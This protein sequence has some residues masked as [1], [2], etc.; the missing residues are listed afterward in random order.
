MPVAADALFAWHARPGALDRLLPPWQAVRIEKRGTIDPGQTV[1]LRVGT[2][3]FAVRIEARHG[4]V[5]PGRSF[6]DEQVSGPFARWRHV[7]R[8]VPRG[9]RESTLEDDIE[10][11]LPL[12]AVAQPLAGGA[13]QAALER[14]FRFRHA[15]TR[16]D[17]ERH[18]SAPRQSLRVAI[19]GASGLVGRNLA[20]FLTTGGHEVLR[21]SRDRSSAPDTI[22]W[23][24]E[25][26]EVDASRLEGVDAVVHLAGESIAAL[27][28][29]SQKKR[30]IRESRVRGTDLLCR[31]LAGLE[32]P[33][34]VLVSASA[35][36]IYGARGEARVDE[37]SD[38]AD[39]FLAEVCL[40]WEAATAPAAA[41]GIRVVNLRIGVVLSAQ[42]GMLGRLRT[43]FALAL[44]G[45]VGSGA[46]WQS[47]I[48]LDDLI[49]AIHASL[50]DTRLAGAVNAVAPAPVT[51]AEL[52]RV[53]AKVLH[54]PA[55]LPLPALAVRRMLGE[56]GESLLLGGAHVTPRRLAEVGFRFIHPDVE[57]ALRFELGRPADPSG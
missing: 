55:R 12:G 52:T 17:L 4:P 57:S 36:G 43:P 1:V 44:G 39:D 35:I 32:R 21:L 47:W 27:R 56:M 46:Q 22:L 7:H 31:T 9:D 38:P 49:G 18:A 51:N 48:S 53:L 41:R 30:A 45:R 19:S 10:Y 15:R 33:P 23:S 11:A 37:R 50:F 3:P 24:P 34:R 14:M 6:V 2:P 25:R 8:C 16:H 40:A 54:R 42:G 20:S 26:D 13:V 29:T 28:W 5:E